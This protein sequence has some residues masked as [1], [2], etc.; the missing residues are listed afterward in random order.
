MGTGSRAASALDS[1]AIPWEEWSDAALDRARAEGKPVALHIGAT[2]CHWCHVMDEGSYTWPGVSALMAERFVCLRVDTDRRPDLNERYNQGG[3]PTFAVLDGAGEV[4]IG[5]TYVPGPE[6]LALLRSASDPSSRWTLAPE[7]AP[8][9]ASSDIGPATIFERVREAWDPYNAG[10]GELQKFPH[11][12]V[13]EWLVDRAARQQDSFSPDALAKTLVAMAT[14]GMY[15]AVEGGFFRYATQDD[16]T[17]PH[18]EKLLEDHAR[19]LAVYARAVGL[20]GPAAAVARATLGSAVKWLLATLYDPLTGAFFGSQDADEGYYALGRGHRGQG[21]GVEAPP[22][23]RT[24]YAGWNGLTA[25][26]LVACAGALGRPGLVGVARGVTEHLLT[27]VD[28]DGRVTRHVGGVAGLL[29]DQVQVAEGFLAVGRAMADPAWFERAGEV[30]R[31]AWDHLRVEGGGLWDRAPGAAG[32]LRHVRRN[33]HGNAAFAKVAGALADLVGGPWS[34]RADEAAAAALAESD[35]WGFFAAPAAQ[36]AERR[37]ARRVVVKVASP[38]W[39]IAPMLL[40]GLAHPDPDCTWV[41][42][43]EGV[44][45][46]KAMACSGSA[47]ARPTA[48]LTELSA[49]IRALRG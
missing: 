24:V 10:F 21:T 4:L 30:L 37:A 20:G 42:V 49:A 19:L 41:G 46:G 3:W 7:P 31:W 29:E 28:G 39:P 47:C 34:D 14:K 6:L 13:L 26:A 32:R 36:V 18:Y 35:D 27:L 44:P 5:R 16:W 15:D 9:L 48:E 38:G 25:A 22:V 33:V 23:D 2:W 17:A 43:R 12:G 8:E 11:P 40:G 45:D 1:A